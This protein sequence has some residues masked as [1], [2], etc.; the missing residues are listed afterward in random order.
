MICFDFISAIAYIVVM[1]NYFETPLTAPKEGESLNTAQA[2]QSSQFYQR[3]LGLKK[4]VQGLLKKE[5]YSNLVEYLRANNF[6]LRGGG[7]TIHLAKEFGFCYGVDLAVEY[8]YQTREKYPDRRIFL[9]CEIIHNPHVTNR[10]IKMGFLFL[11]V[12]DC[13]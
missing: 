8:A 10:L 2:T 7:L 6:K 11:R 3:G 9:T 13:N 4:E 5:Y 1:K 12:H